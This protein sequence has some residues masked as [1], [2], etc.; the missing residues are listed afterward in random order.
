MSERF[1]NRLA[2]YHDLLPCPFCG[3]LHIKYFGTN[4]NTLYCRSCGAEGPQGDGSF[5]DAKKEWNK[6]IVTK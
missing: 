6:R 2:E 4:G 5:D 1:N 3:S